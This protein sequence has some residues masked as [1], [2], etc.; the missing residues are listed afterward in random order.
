MVK[1]NNYNYFMKLAL[2]EAIISFNEGE[3]PVGAVFVDNNEVIAAS[4][5]APIALNDPTAHAEILVIR[6]A[7]ELKNNYSQLKDKRS[8]WETHWQEVADLIIP[9]KSDIVDQKVRGDKRHI[10]VFDGT[11]IHSLELLASSLHACLLPL[12]IVGFL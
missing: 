2:E 3:V 10:Q 8:N 1:N 9:R 5:N 11:A 7:A 6:K 12:L 4:G